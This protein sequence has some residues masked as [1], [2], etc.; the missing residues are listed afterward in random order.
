[1]RVTVTK[2]ANGDLWANGRLT[3]AGLT[4]TD[5]IRRGQSAQSDVE[6]YAALIERRAREL[7]KLEKEN[8]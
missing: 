6:C 3:S 2:D 1:M 5:L 7:E 4:L 8:R